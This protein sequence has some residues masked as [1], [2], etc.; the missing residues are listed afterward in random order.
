MKTCEMCLGPIEKHRPGHT[1]YCL[2]C[3]RDKEKSVNR[4]RNKRRRDEIREQFPHIPRRKAVLH[5]NGRTCLKCNEPVRTTLAKLE[6]ARLCYM[7]FKANEGLGEMCEGMVGDS[8]GW[9][10]EEPIP[11]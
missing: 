8:G 5:E 2:Q 1:K 10:M 3:S 4:E 11:K 9:H 6:H 7:C